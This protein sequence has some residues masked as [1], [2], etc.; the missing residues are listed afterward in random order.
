FAR[1][2]KGGK[3]NLTAEWA[4]ANPTLASEWVN[5]TDLLKPFVKKW[6]E[7]HPEVAAEWKK[8]NEGADGDPSE[9]DLGPFFFASYAKPHPGPFRGT[10]EEMKEGKKEKVIRPVT[11]G[12]EV[13]SVFFDTWLTEN[14]EKIDPLK[15]LEQVPA[16][17]VMTSG[18]GLDPHITLRNARYQLD[19]VVEARAKESK[20][21]EKEVRAVIEGI[22]KEHQFTPL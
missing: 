14:P 8:A 12:D 18:S 10:V 22:L 4:K 15:D 5:S 19:G 11:T 16:D 13:R 20:R 21:A 7:D 6:A 9:A 2:N 1:A 17:M 3:S